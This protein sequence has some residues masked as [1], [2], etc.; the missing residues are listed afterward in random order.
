MYRR[1]EHFRVKAGSN[2]AALSISGSVELCRLLGFDTSQ[3]TEADHPEFDVLELPF[4]DSSFDAVV[5]DQVLEHVEG[6]PRRA[7]AESL[8][9]LKPG[10]ICIHTSCLV[11]P[12]HFGPGDYW[13]FTPD[14][15]RLLVDHT[16]DVVESGGW[17]NRLAVIAMA[18]GLRM[19]PI[20]HLR[21]HPL[22]RLAVATDS[23]WLIATWIVLR[24]PVVE[25]SRI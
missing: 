4:E 5:S 1:L 13:R 24:K 20:P 23:K 3:V 25:A 14:G 2:Q 15:L 9:V 22:H 12:I 6:D 21:I 10:G 18:V 19:A 11:N 7:V 16:V 8:R 17:G